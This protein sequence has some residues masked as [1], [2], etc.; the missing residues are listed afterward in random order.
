MKYSASEAWSEGIGAFRRASDLGS[1]NWL[2]L[3]MAFE[4]S[5]ELEK[6]EEAYRV[7]LKEFPEDADLMVNLG[8]L[9][10]QAD[11]Y[12]ESTLILRAAA[13]RDPKANWVLADALLA[14]GDEESALDALTAAIDAG[15]LRAHLDRA[16]LLLARD[17][18]PVP[19]FLRAIESG[20]RFA[21]REYAL[22]LHSVGDDSRSLEVAVE[23]IDYGDTL[24]YLPAALS[25]TA[26]G[27]YEDAVRWFRLAI[28]DG[29]DEYEDELREALALL[30]RSSGTGS[31]I[32]DRI[33]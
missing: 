3:A 9:L 31:D 21:R 10:L 33:D 1:P 12:Q 14:G 4:G 28:E 16:T 19:D 29:D 27:Q 25:A 20:A 2:G 7:G 24:S 26:L 17:D 30:A 8:V 13:R 5:G 18:N 11:R 15:E 22:Y 23:A 6:A 32:G